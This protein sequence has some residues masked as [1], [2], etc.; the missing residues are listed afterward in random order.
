MEHIDLEVMWELLRRLMRNNA[1]A[2]DPARFTISGM[3]HE[4]K[5]ENGD[6]DKWPELE[7]LQNAVSAFMGLSRDDKRRLL[8]GWSPKVLDVRRH[9]HTKQTLGWPLRPVLLMWAGA[10]QLLRSRP[11]RVRCDLRRRLSHVPT[12]HQGWLDQ[13]GSARRTSRSGNAD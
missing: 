8:G 3:V 10:G 7:E 11:R 5:D 9:E 4:F 1:S 12:F 13:S 2:G 6:A